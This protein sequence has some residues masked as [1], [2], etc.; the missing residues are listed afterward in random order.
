MTHHRNGLRNRLCQPV[1]ALLIRCG[2][3]VVGQIR[4]DVDQLAVE[5]V[6]GVGHNLLLHNRFHIGLHLF[7]NAWTFHRPK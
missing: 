1:A 2:R 3:V 6:D 4:L 7:P 5:K